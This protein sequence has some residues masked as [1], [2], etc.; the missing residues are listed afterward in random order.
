MRLKILNYDNYEV[1]ENGNVYNKKKMLKP[2][3]NNNGYYRVYLSKKGKVKKL[4]IHRLVAE[5][6][7]P[8]PNKL[9]QVNHKDGNKKNNKVENLEWCTAKENINHS[10]K[11]GLS[12][13]PKGNKNHLY[14][15]RGNET[16]YHKKIIQYDMNKKIIKH[17]ESMIQ[18]ERELGISVSTISSCCRGITKTSGGYIWGYEK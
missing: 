9:P 14:G 17:W 1:D 4:Y 12:F 18:A 8:N 7:I 13:V 11:I 15:K 2:Q 6:F 5:A 16:P 3:L 10:F